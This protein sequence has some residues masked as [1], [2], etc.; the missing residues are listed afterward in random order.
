MRSLHTEKDF[1]D[2]FTF[3]PGGDI[4]IN[5]NFIGKSLYRE[6][7]SLAFPFSISNITRGHITLYI[8]HDLD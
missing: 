1:C 5:L 3:I 2:V 4:I 8:I 6:A 7:A